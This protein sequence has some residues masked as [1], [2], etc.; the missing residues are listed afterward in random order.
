MRLFL[1]ACVL[2]LALSVSG[3]GSSKVVT[4]TT[5]QTVTQTVVHHA[6]APRRKAKP[7]TVKQ[8]DSSGTSSP[9]GYVSSYPV[10]FERRFNSRCSGKGNG[11]SFCA[12]VRR[13]VERHV[14]YSVFLA[15][16]RTLFTTNPPSWFATAEDRCFTP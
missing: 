13:Y 11:A 15:D 14:P 6:A 9:G 3:C 8:S 16:A 2:G 1:A 10:S 12:C 5:T 4:V 7:H